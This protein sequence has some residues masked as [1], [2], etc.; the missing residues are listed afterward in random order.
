MK[1]QWKRRLTQTSLLTAMLTMAIGGAGS[2]FA[3]D[4]AADQATTTPAAVVTT[5]QPAVKLTA[6]AAAPAMLIQPALQRNYWKLLSATY[7][8]ETSA[9]WKQ[10]LDER[11]QVEADMPKPQ[12]T[13]AVM[14]TK[15]AEIGSKAQM[16]TVTG[17]EDADGAEAKDNVPFSQIVRFEQTLPPKEGETP[18]G[19]GASTETVPALKVRIIKDGAELKDIAQALPVEGIK[20]DDIM[21]VELPESFK[22]QQQLAEA[23]DAD[24]A[25]TIKSLLPLLLTDYKQETEQLRDVSQKMKAAQAAA[26]QT[27]AA[28]Q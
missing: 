27:E 6:A 16:I 4:T 26:Q 24:D 5:S 3:A 11:K 23:V 9:A 2:A 21:K 17:S 13:S 19:Q 14:I 8:P 10:A 18:N 22:R 28:K 15:R 12:I 20:A 7:A 25:A 1:K